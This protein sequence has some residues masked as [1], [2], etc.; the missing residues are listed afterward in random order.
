MTMDLVRAKDYESA[1]RVGTS[2]LSLDLAAWRVGFEIETYR[3]RFPGQG[4]FLLLY[5]LFEGGGEGGD[6]N[7]CYTPNQFPSLKEEVE[8]FLRI[9][10]SRDA[11]KPLYVSAQEVRPADVESFLIRL[12][13]LIDE[14]A[15]N[16]ECVFAFAD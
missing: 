8:N 4:R 13:L 16:N 5:R 9:F 14:A 1:C 15:A 11:S 12:A 10:A 3:A 2:H 7:V 6:A